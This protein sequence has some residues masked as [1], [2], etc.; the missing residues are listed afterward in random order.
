MEPETKVPD[1]FDRVIGYLHDLPDVVHT[2]PTAKRSVMPMVG[3]AQL[4]YVQTYRQREVGDTIFIETVREGVTIRI[5]IPPNV[6][7]VIARQRASLTTMCRKRSAK[8][9]AQARMERGEVPGFMKGKR[10][11]AAASASA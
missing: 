7:D 4:Y 5:A 11:K 6:A 3:T 2:K 8:A 9:T 1:A 10:G